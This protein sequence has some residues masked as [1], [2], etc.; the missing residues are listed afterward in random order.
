MAVIRD[1]MPAFE[2]FQPATIDE[3]V[4][5]AGP[6]RVV[7]VGDGRRDGYVRLAEGPHEAAERGGR[8]EPDGGAARDQRGQRR[9]S[10]SA[11]RRR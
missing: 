6:A 9:A 8:P 2:L 4:N 1:M 11:R 5:A 10:R 7:G 3:A